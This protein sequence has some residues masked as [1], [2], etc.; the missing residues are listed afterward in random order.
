VAC[1]D[2]RINKAGRYPHYT[3]MLWSHATPRL[4]K[5]RASH[6]IILI[7]ASFGPRPVRVNTEQFTRAVARPRRYPINQAATRSYF[8]S[9]HVA[10]GL[11]DL[12][13]RFSQRDREAFF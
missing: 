5:Y 3:V 11:S 2:G 4:E 12:R 6:P 10:R 9:M 13:P 1:S 8:S 7:S